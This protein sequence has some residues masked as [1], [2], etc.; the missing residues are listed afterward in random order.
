MKYDLDYYRGTSLS[1]PKPPTKPKLHHKHSSFEAKCYA[2][3]LEQYE[4][5]VS[6]YEDDLNHYRCQMVKRMNELQ[7]E[8]KLDYGLSES[9]AFVLW[10]EAYENGHSAGLQEVLYHYDNL[11]TFI[12]KYM[13]LR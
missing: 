8:L 12:Q 5:E 7:E 3:D 4:K 9:Q 6:V 2:E 11:Y 13:K 1:V 10:N